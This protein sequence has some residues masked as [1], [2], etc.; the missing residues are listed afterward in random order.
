MGLITSVL[1]V[2]GV[3]EYMRLTGGERGRVKVSILSR[4]WVTM[5]DEDA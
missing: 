2:L 5:R 3:E 1:V 4:T